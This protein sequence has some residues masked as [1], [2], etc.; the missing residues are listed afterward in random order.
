M[1]WRRER[2]ARRDVTLVGREL[3]VFARLGL[4]Y[5]FVYE[6]RAPRTMLFYVMY[7][8]RRRR[9]LMHLRM[10]RLNATAEAGVA[11]AFVSSLAFASSSSARRRVGSSARR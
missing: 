6:A 7:M 5:K 8:H 3:C 4:S 10:S 1:T 11:S 2:C 9:H